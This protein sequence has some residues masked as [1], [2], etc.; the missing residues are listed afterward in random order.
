MGDDWPAPRNRAVGVAMGRR[1][2][3][4]GGYLSLSMGD[5]WVL[6]WRGSAKRPL[7]V[8]AP[9]RGLAA[10]FKRRSACAAAPCLGGV[11]IHGGNVEERGRSFHHF[12]HFLLITPHPPLSAPAPPDTE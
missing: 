4:L 6:Q 2:L 5:A 1:A 7:A 12:H 10:L 3:L 8:R 11:L 9:V